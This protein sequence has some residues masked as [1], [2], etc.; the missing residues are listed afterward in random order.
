MSIADLTIP[1][2]QREPIVPLTEREVQQTV[3][4]APQ[5]ITFSQWLELCNDKHD[6]RELVN[7]T[8]VE[9]PMVQWEHEKAEQWLGSLLVFYVD[10]LDLGVMKGSRSP[11]KVDGLRGRMPDLFFVRRENI[12]IVTEKATYGTPDMV[13]EFRSPNDFE[14]GMAALESDYRALGVPEIIFVDV[15]RGKIRVLRR[16]HAQT[17]EYD[18]ES[19]GVGETL[20]LQAL[21]GL[22]LK[23]DWLLLEPRPALNATFQKLLRFH[24]TADKTVASDDLAH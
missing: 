23:T 11:V 22:E 2:M 13:M 21:G 8:L 14:P 10:E 7:G 5:P 4:V 9:K 6:Y 15:R 3:W 18:Q 20:T 24:E 19:L 17:D 12:G 1:R 16:S